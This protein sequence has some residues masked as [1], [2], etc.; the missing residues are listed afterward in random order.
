MLDTFPYVQGDIG[1]LPGLGKSYLLGENVSN[2]IKLDV[3]YSQEKF[4]RP[5]IEED[6]V[7][8]ASIHDIV[9]MKVDVVSIGGRKK[10]FWDLLE[11]TDNIDLTRTLAL[12]EE[13][14]PYVH[15]RSQIVAN[16]TDFETADDDFNPICLRGKYWD[17]IKDDFLEF[18]KTYNLNDGA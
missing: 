7:R 9:A 12:H 13:R 8:L 10:D 18:T 15:D 14:N 11:L 5:F 4:I 17:F 6:G 1:G 3:Y 2:H 16:F